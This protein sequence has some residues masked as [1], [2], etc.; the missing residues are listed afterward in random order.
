MLQLL[1]RAVDQRNLAC[2][3]SSISCRVGPCHADRLIAKQD[4][5][6]LCMDGKWNFWKLTISVLCPQVS[7]R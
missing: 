7:R 1:R 4:G 6:A 5:D 2:T 3:P